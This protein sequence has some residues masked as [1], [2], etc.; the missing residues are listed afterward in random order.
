MMVRALPATGRTRALAVLAFASAVYATALTIVRTTAFAERPDA[1]AFGV[2]VDLTCLVPLAYW[3][4]MVRRGGAARTSLVPVVALSVLGATLV[5]PAEHRSFVGLAR[6][7]IVPLELVLVGYGVRGARRALRAARALGDRDAA[8]ALE[9]GFVAALGDRIAP[10]ILAAEIATVHYALFARAAAPGTAPQDRG[11][12]FSQLGARSGATAWGF[13]LAIVV[14]TVVLHLWLAR[15]YPAAAW[16]STALGAY[17]LLWLAGHHRAV[18]LR[19]VVLAGDTLALR[20]GLRLT[21]RVPLAAVAAV[22]ELSWRTVP[23]PARGYLDAA[24][25]AEPNVVVT[26][27][28]PTVVTGA[29]GLRRTVTRLGLRLDDAAGFVAAVRLRREGGPP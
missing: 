17:S 29:F 5:L 6:Y 10:R 28:E 23:S 2:A 24:Q 1:L 25:P 7:A 9:S 8:E 16:G 11:A 19:H 27:A 4:A 26:L 18:G 3:A 22:E 13:G 21:A 14:E 12:A 20:A 15:S